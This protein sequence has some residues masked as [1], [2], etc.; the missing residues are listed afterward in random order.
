MTTD[1]ELA[2]QAVTLLQQ[3]V[4]LQRKAENA[5]VPVDLDTLTTLLHCT[6]KY[7]DIKLAEKPS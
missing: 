4:D 7:I 1:W 6:E 5:T 2:R 3:I